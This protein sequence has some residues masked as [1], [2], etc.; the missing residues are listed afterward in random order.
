VAAC[1]TGYEYPEYIHTYGNPAVTMWQQVMRA[2]HENLEYK[3]FNV[4]KNTYL[5][6]VPGVTE[7]NYVIRGVNE[8]GVVLYEDKGKGVEKREIEVTARTIE[9]YTLVGSSP[10]KFKLQRSETDNIITFVYK[11][12]NPTPSPSPSPSGS[13]SGGGGWY[14]G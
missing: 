14:F 8:S 3:S 4:P 10:I 6:P 7:V 13:G 5:T 11:N 1:W 12:N 2:V 9:G